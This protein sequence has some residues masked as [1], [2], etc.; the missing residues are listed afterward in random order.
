MSIAE[1]VWRVL[2]EGG[3]VERDAVAEVLV[4]ARAIAEVAWHPTGF[5]V[6]KLRI[7]ERGVLRLH[8][9]PETERVYGEPL[10][11]VH[12]H[13]FA[14]RS[15]VLVG[16]VTSREHDVVEDSEGSMRRWAVDYGAVRDSR[17]VPH[18]EPVQARTGPS[19]TTEAGGTYSVEAGRFHAS[20]VPA[21][22]LAATLVATTGTDRRYP[23]VLGPA[24]GSE[25]IVVRRVAVPR[26]RWQ[27]WV[28]RV[29][30]AWASA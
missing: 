5:V 29:A 1:H 15:L 8:V 30:E 7:T 2:G 27:A 6:G 16:R 28:D 18:G 13:V 10:W 17:L 25:P 3:T 22:Q 11:P 4:R 12:D 21:G 9:W 23:F 14:L 20:M 19:V 24:R 26:P